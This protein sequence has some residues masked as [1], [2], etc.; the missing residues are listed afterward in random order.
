MPRPIVT[1]PQTWQTGSLPSVRPTAAPSRRPSA[2]RRRWL[3]TPLAAIIAGAGML[4]A[5]PPVSAADSQAVSALTAIVT[6][7]AATA[8]R[9]PRIDD[10]AA[11]VESVYVRR[12]W[13]PLWSRAGIPTATARRLIAALQTIGERGLS[14][15]DYD[16]DTLA[17]L[18]T[19]DALTPLQRADFDA[20]LSVAALRA[21]RALR[22]G[23]IPADEA[24]AHLRLPRDSVDFPGALASLASALSPAALLDAAEPPYVHYRLLR[25]VLAQYRALPPHDTVQ[26]RITQ[27]ARTLE[28]WRWLP[29]QFTTSP[30]IV[31]IPAFRLYAL[32]PNS[33]R[34]QEMLRMDVVVG[35]AWNHRTPVFSEMMQHVIFAPYWDVPQSIALAELVPQALKN[36]R[37]LPLN[38]YQILDARERVIPVTLTAVRAVQAGRARIRQLPGGTNA[39]GRV[40]FVFPNAFNVY[41]HDTPVQTAFT[42]QRRDLSHGCIRVA[43]PGA[44]ARRVLQAQPGWD[45]TAVA[46]AMSRKV[47]QRVDLTVPIP[48][49][50][51]YATVVAREDGAA[52]FYTDIYG[53]DAEL[54]VQLARGYPYVTRRRPAA[55]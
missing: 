29:H 47:P 52:L 40:K 30:V 43:D 27:I 49:H 44:L 20:M 34:E 46:A 6:G 21:F 8:M 4:Q 15:A 7:G 17:A 45:S 2:V 33:D 19:R 5:Q 37:I 13:A 25:G 36:P 16:A 41:L 31:N 50:I 38:N 28:R 42:R 24:H 12:E 51:V 18:A 55:P 54:G 3:R 22:V 10:V 39:L 35:D 11:D 14:A 32:S 9:W 48:V 53:L 26:A 1:A 23:R